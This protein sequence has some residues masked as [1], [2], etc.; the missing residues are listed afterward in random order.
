MHYKLELFSTFLLFA[1][2]YQFHL[3]YSPVPSILPT[4]LPQ[5]TIEFRSEPDL[6]PFTLA[7]QESW[8]ALI[9]H[10][11]N[12]AVVRDMHGNT[13]SQGI[14]VYHRLHCL[15]ALRGQITE[16]LAGGK[17]ARATYNGAESETQ[18][19]HLGHC[20]DL[21]RQVRRIA[22]SMICAEVE[23]GHADEDS[24]TRVSSAMWT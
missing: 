16:F 4:T 10:N 5:T 2:L 13:I 23:I 20:L 7:T 14:E 22:R 18:R 21:L 15:T 9:P 11:W 8:T 24:G 19:L 1:L 17:D 12:H 6:H 3:T